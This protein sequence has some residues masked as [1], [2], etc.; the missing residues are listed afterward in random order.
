VLLER[1]VERATLRGLVEGVVDGVSAVG[2]V[3]GAAGIGKSR[4]LVGAREEAA[5][6]GVRVLAASARE[7]ERDHGFGVVGQ[8]V[9]PV[10]GL[11]PGAGPVGPSF[12][13]LHELYTVAARLA[14][15]QPLLLA[16]DD[17][18]W[19][20]AA[21]LRFLAYL[22]T[23]L[24]G[25]PVLLLA[26]LR[27]S[28]PATDPAAQHGLLA[29]PATVWVRPLPLS[30]AAAGTLV[31][32]A[33]PGVAAPEFV[34]GCHRATGGN[35]LLLEQL[36]SAL[37]AEQVTPEAANLG[38]LDE[39]GPAAV[40]R[41]VLL[42]LGRLGADAVAAAKALAV[43]GDGA[44]LAQVAALA[45]LDVHVAGRAVA[46]LVRS[47]LVRAEPP[48]GFVHPLVGASVHRDVPIGERELQHLRAA[49][50][51]DEA[52]GAPEQVAGHLLRAPALGDPWVVERLVDAAAV[53][54]GKGATEG[55]AAYL[56]RALA[57]PPAPER[58]AELVW[59]LGRAQA[60]RNGPAAVAHLRAAYEHLGAD[61][62]RRGV[63]AE[64][65]GRVLVFTGAREEA[66]RVIR[67]SAASL[68]A[69]DD[70]RARLE[71]F[72]LFVPLYTTGDP[73]ELARLEA[74]RS[75][76]LAP[77]L[78]ARRLA[79][80]AATQW[81]YA[82]GPC[83]EVSELV[84]AALA[85]GSLVDSEPSWAAFA[86]TPLSFADHPQAAGLWDRLTTA[87]YEHGS[88]SS[89]VA[90]IRGRAESLWRR[91]DLSEA[92]AWTEECL[93]VIGQWGFDQPAPTY[94]HGQLAGILL[95]RGD[96]VAARRA[97]SAGVD[98]GLVDPGTRGWLGRGLEL[99]LA[100]GADEEVPAAATAYAERFDGLVPNPMDVPW[101]SLAAT[102]LHRLGRT[103]EGRALAE[104]ELELARGWGGPTTV[105]RTLRTLGA[106]EG[107]GGVARLEE[108]VGVVEASPARLEHARCL[109]ALG[110]ALARAGRRSAARAPLAEAL[111]IATDCEARALAAQA[112]T[113]LL[114]AGGRPRRTAVRGLASLTP[115]ELRVV[116]L[117]AEGRTNREVGEELFVT[118]KT[119]AMHLSNAYRKL[120]VSSRSELSAA[121]GEQARSS[122]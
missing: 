27:P 114:A 33:L 92:Q 46:A 85:D 108:A 103:A 109:A 82:G 61:P 45:G 107:P 21:S 110:A 60:E 52:G 71:A 32:A 93:T 12:A 86:M 88:L 2:V 25:L 63:V 51:L 3:E 99:L 77:G 48:L 40:G 55:A 96:A 17:L 102:A 49:R 115:G 121:L 76:V 95:D 7:L 68:P 106:L 113:E 84:L 74:H 72:E 24:E 67:G 70:Q 79:A 119:V 94:C 41:S 100:E 20:D 14:E 26:T 117:A 11:D 90:V 98:T 57:E 56:E 13:V 38:L 105:A 5:A 1:R 34:A 122:G 54:T 58:R 44:D 112:R 23:R 10:A 87:G 80:V 28:V 62:E 111:A 29:D 64:M 15:Q 6:A 36:V 53:A 39:V 47:D 9:G 16:V 104:Q 42:R 116:L 31:D 120:G 22:R 30:P 83:A 43:L 81:M 69:G 97:W 101:R 37:A 78:G 35:P 66:A 19:C 118:P 4:L 73:A 65:L 50:L 8:L 91:G 59:E 89:M 75:P 18:H